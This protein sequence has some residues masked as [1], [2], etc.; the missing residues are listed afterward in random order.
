MQSS[1]TNLAVKGNSLE[2]S[3]ENSS[4]SSYWKSSN[5]PTEDD[6][7]LLSDK[8]RRL[9]SNTINA[10]ESADGCGLDAGLR[11][12]NDSNPNPNPEPE[13]AVNSKGHHESADDSVNKTSNGNIN[14][15]SNEYFEADDDNVHNKTENKNE[16]IITSSLEPILEIYSTTIPNQ[17][18]DS[19]SRQ[20]LKSIRSDVNTLNRSLLVNDLR[21]HIL[22]FNG[23]ARANDVCRVK[24]LSEEGMTVKDDVLID[25]TDGS[26]YPDNVPKNQSIPNEEGHPRP[27]ISSSHSK[28]IGSVVDSNNSYK[29]PA[30]DS[31]TASAVHV[32]SVLRSE[33]FETLRLKSSK[34]ES[35][36]F[37]ASSED[38]YS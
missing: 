19:S 35:S 28:G 23:K 15:T 31:T 8:L 2:D 11:S 5:F 27:D 32:N 25:A 37:Y 24:S 30:S 14:V 6:F 26:H 33:L 4:M 17:P 1:S 29:A 18:K 20:S 12:G 36:Q 21:E 22:L 7:G 38:D 3:S 34:L 10:F 9:Y 16:A 13:N